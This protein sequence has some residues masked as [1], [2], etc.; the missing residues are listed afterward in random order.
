MS[1][2]PINQ[3][4]MT[5]EPSDMMKINPPMPITVASS[6]TNQMDVID[7]DSFSY[8]G[9][10]VVR[11]EFFAHIYEPSFT[12]NNYKVSVNTA[13]IKKLPDV[14]YVQILVNPIEKKLAVRPCREEEKD[15]FRW[16]SSGK[17]RSPKQITC[18]IFF[19]KV[20]SLMDW[21]PNYRYKILGKL[22][23][24]GNEILFIFDLT[25][26][27]IF[28]RT[29]KDNG[30]VTT[31]RTPSYPEEWKNQFGIP[32]EEHQKSMQVNIFEG[33]AVFDI[34]EKKKATDKSTEK[35]KEPSTAESEEKSYEQQTLF[36]S[37]NMY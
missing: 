16:C 7:D 10:Q 9:Y 25:S 27:E 5:T 8:D 31:A 26:P 15:S 21:N 11:G 18:R 2:Q 6:P 30:T 34:Q 14:E 12:F 32:V 24:S 28:P 13:C 22:I 23:R 37:T 36:P 4:N 29:L 19:S 35:T 1:D 17:K 33:Y 20:I 3:W